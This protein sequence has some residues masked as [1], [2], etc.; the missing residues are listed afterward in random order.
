MSRF[1]YWFLCMDKEYDASE[2]RIGS[3]MFWRVVQV[4]SVVF[5][6]LSILVQ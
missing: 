6:V 4:M 5:I 1:M 3:P 2:H